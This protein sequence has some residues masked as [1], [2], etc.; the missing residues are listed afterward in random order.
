MTATND[1]WHYTAEASG[2]VK[3]TTGGSYVEEF[4]WS[5]MTSKGQAVT[6]QPATAQ[7][8]ELLSLDP[9]W[10]P[11]GPDLTKAERQMV[12]P[13]TDLFTFYVD[14]WLVNK[15]GALRQPG[16]HFHVPNPQVGSW[17]DGTHVLI[18][19][20]HIEFDLNLQSIDQAKQTAVIMVHHVPPSH[21]NL[22]FPA[23]W[24]L[25][26][27]A[28]TSNNWV[29]VRK[30]EDGNYLAAVGKETFDVSIVVSTADGR[31]LSADMDNPV[32]TRRRQCHDAALTQ[33]GDANPQT[34]HRHVAI[35]LEQ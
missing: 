33:C 31:I 23:A 6:L 27:V 3:K 7:S 34:I 24:M 16:D 9:G 17:G 32:V 35:V 22:E 12:G 30:T 4:R 21:P 19:K 8:R 5:N 29:E 26:P 2:R 18:G 28:D 13:I 11:S 25:A 14:L 15:I 20:D 1:D 10:M